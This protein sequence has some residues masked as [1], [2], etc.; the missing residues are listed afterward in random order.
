MGRHDLGYERVI[1]HRCGRQ[2]G[3]AKY[4]MRDDVIYICMPCIVDIY[5]LHFNI[6]PRVHYGSLDKV[7]WMMIVTV[8]S[9]ADITS[10]YKYASAP[11]YA[12][13]FYSRKIKRGRIESP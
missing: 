10:M 12:T 13:D 8:E 3:P 1:C 9:S 5:H 2:I 11:N 4:G 6:P 7:M